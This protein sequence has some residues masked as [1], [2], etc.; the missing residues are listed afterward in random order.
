MDDLDSK[1]I[2]LITGATGY[3][4]RRLTHHLLHQNRYGVR[5]FVRN[6]RKIQTAIA[7]SVEIYEGST[8][9]PGTLTPALK[10]VD[11][12]YYL[13]HSMGSDEDYR[14]LDLKSAENFRRACVDAG[15]RRIIYLGGLGNRTS[16]SKHLLSR[17]ETGE[18]LSAEPEKISTIWLRA[19]VIVGSGSASFEIVR[20]LCHKLPFMLTPR[21]VRTLSLIHI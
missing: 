11:T 16:A 6:K 9:E 10:D 13:I 15:V 3:I 14:T 4:G 5:L 17:I 20:N 7:D 18:T 19:G 8:F 21:W 12:A 2:I 1:P